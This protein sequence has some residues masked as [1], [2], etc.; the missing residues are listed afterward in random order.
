MNK[1]AF[2]VRLGNSFPKTN[3]PIIFRD[4]IYNGQSSYDIKTGYFTCE[5]AGV[6]EFSFY[7]TISNKAAS[8][9]LMR[10]GEVILHSYNTLQ[11]GSTTASGSIYFRLNKGDRVWL[12]A[13]HGQNGLTKDS[14]FSGHLLFTE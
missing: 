8:V 5:V 1:I 4:V 7:C 10:N 9:D 12:L 2:S 14:V 13:K 6:Y 3:Q 11:R